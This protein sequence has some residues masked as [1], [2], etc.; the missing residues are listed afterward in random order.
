MC[1]P[2]DSSDLVYRQ[3]H[4]THAPGGNPSSQAFNPTPKD[5]GQLSLDNAGLVTAEHSWSHFTKNL[6][7]QSAGTWALSL[8]EIQ[9][10][11]DLELFMSPVVDPEDATRSN[12][13]HCLLD[14]NRIASKGERKRRAQR[15]A[16]QASTRGCLFQAPK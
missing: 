2:W 8:E 11:G 16:I 15:L 3:V 10:A 4:P 13:A 12:P 9:A 1:Q 6:G 7:F 5:Q 14:F